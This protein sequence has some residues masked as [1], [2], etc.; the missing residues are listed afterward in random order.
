MLFSGQG[1]CAPVCSRGF[2]GIPDLQIAG[3]PGIQRY[4]VFPAQFR[5]LG[6]AHRL[7]CHFH[8]SLTG[9]EEIGKMPASFLKQQQLLQFQ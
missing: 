7:Q 1:S 8:L 6:L 9:R 4:Q 5:N 2:S 3:Q